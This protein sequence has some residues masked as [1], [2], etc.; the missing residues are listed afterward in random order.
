MDNARTTDLFWS[1]IH[2]AITQRI[3]SGVDL[4]YVITPYIKL[5]HS[6]TLL[7]QLLANP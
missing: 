4:I 6:R 5:D 7:K 2:S 1:P 3:E